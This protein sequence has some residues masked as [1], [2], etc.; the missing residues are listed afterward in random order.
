MLLPNDN[1]N[2]SILHKLDHVKTWGQEE[3]W[4]YKKKKCVHL[5]EYHEMMN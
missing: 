1:D 4:V 2:T 5:S 3:K